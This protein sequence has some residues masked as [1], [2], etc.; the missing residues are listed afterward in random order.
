MDTELL[1]PRYAEQINAYLDDL[2]R[3]FEAEGL[4]VARGADGEDWGD[5]DTR[6]ELIIEPDNEDGADF[7]IQIIGSDNGW[8]APE[9]DGLNV[10]VD[11]TKMGGEMLGSICPMNY[12]DDVWVNPE[13]LPELD[14]RV[15]LVLAVSVWDWVAAYWEGVS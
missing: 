6:W 2:A 4:T 13:N 11:L 8:D 10:M 12:T 15:D 3:A 9:R 7:S 14:R 1:K 5:G